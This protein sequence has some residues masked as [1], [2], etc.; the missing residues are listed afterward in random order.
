MNREKRKQKEGI[1]DNNKYDIQLSKHKN[2][3]E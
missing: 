3:N 1:L 2:R